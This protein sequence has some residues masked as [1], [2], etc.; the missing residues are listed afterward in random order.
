MHVRLSSTGQKEAAA[1]FPLPRSKV[2][3]TSFS[4]SWQSSSKDR[5]PVHAARTPGICEPASRVQ[6]GNDRKR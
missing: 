5:L 3:S 1:S 2:H 6:K 4:L